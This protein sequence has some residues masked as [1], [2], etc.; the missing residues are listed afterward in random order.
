M[1][2]LT[3]SEL[4]ICTKITTT[5]QTRGFPLSPVS[6]YI[7]K[8]LCLITVRSTQN[9]ARQVLGLF[10]KMYMKMYLKYEYKDSPHLIL[11][12]INIYNK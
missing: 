5:T 2:N 1:E 3:S 6:L 8:G 12:E 7:L 9:T 4:V 11:E 10:P